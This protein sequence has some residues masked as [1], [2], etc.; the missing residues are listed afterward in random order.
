MSILEKSAP[1]KRKTKTPLVLFS[2]PI[3]PFILTPC[4][5]PFPIQFN[6]NYS[7]PPVFPL[8]FHFLPWFSPFMANSLWLFKN[9]EFHSSFSI[10]FPNLLKSLCFPYLQP[11][12]S[13]RTS[14]Q[15]R[16][17]LWS[18]R[19][20]SSR[21]WSKWWLHSSRRSS[22]WWRRSA[23]TRGSSESWSSF[24]GSSWHAFSLL[25]AC[26]N[27]KSLLLCL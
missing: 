10:Q 5:Q 7:F 18:G 16:P 21:W 14:R 15:S 26:E 8:F 25:L 6:P 2:S 11:F 22:F 4:F 1:P 3:S 17:W 9:S 24:A 12:S 20:M 23:R 27:S 19:S 13:L